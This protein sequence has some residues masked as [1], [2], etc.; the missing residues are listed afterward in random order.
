[1][2]GCESW[3][4]KKAE[5]WRIELWS[6]R[7]LL[8]FPWTE[9]RSNQSILKE[10]S[11]E[12]SLE[13]LILKLKLQYSGHLMWRNEELTHWKRPWCW[14]RLNAGGEGEDRGWCGWVASQTQWTWV[15]ASS[16][17]WWRTGKP[18]VLQSMASQRAGHNWAS[19]LNWL[20]YKALNQFHSYLLRLGLMS[21]WISSIC[22]PS[23][24][25]ISLGNI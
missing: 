23:T 4:I 6:W 17:S 21:T 22:F 18:G 20:N 16:G 3:T 14:E 15:W 24:H 10:I 9:R 25:S 1:M 5:H 12:Y 7:G 13:E 11:P 8:R 19:E 2:Y